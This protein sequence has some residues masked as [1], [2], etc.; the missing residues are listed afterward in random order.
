MVGNGVGYCRSGTGQV[1]MECYASAV[2]INTTVLNLE[3]PFCILASTRVLWKS[4]LES[5][6]GELPWTMIT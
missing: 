5:R 1:W 2:E 4:E 3:L 6:R